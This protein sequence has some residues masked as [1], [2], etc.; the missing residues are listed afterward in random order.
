MKQHKHRPV[1]TKED[2]P[3]VVV[4]A[5]RES[6]PYYNQVL[7]KHAQAWGK[8]ACDAYEAVQDAFR[9]DDTGVTDTTLPDSETIIYMSADQLELALVAYGVKRIHEVAEI[10]KVDQLLVSID[11]LKVV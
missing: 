1:I 3:G 5:L 4:R 11:Q 7:P 2:H 9:L 8:T 6:I 10:Q